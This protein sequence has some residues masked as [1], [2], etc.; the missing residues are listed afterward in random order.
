MTAPPRT[1]PGSGAAKGE[2]RDVVM[3]R[4]RVGVTGLAAVFLLTLLAASIFTLLGQDDHAARLAN[5]APA[6]AAS[7]S[8][9]E[10]P[11]EPLA[12]LGVA[13]GANPPKA[14]TGTMPTT[15]APA[16]TTVTATA[17]APATIGASPAV[18]TPPPAQGNAT[19]A[20]PRATPQ[21]SAAPH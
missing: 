9:D 4:V 7:N 1:G 14:A 10:T 3:Q 16:T 13:P 8:T 19:A 17:T 12:E 2:P 6:G 18:Q 11:K 5:G 15:A 20:P 21:G